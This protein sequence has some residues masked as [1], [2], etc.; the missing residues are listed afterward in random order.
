MKT[1]EF[2][3]KEVYGN[4]REYVK[5]QGDANI[6]QALTGQKTIDGRIRELVRDLSGGSIEFRQVINLTKD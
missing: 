3:T 5:N 6:L 2:Y 4:R 1:I